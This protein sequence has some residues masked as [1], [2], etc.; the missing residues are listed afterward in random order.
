MENKI[1]KWDGTES[2]IKEILL[3]NSKVFIKVGHDRCPPCNVIT[4]CIEEHT[5]DTIL[6]DMD[7]TI[8]PKGSKYADGVFP[9]WVSVFNNEVINQG[10]GWGCLGNIDDCLDKREPRGADTL[11]N[12]VTFVV[13]EVEG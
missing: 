6:L 1:I 5:D 11:K 3:N 9:T 2:Q 7:V 4:K 8:H 13:S 10:S 12:F